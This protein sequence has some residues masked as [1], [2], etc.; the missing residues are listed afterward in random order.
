MDLRVACSFYGF[1][2]L[3][4]LDLCLQLRALRKEIIHSEQSSDK[5]KYIQYSDKETYVIKNLCQSCFRHIVKIYESKISID[6]RRLG[7]I[8]SR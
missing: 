6:I 8:N 5:N 4:H 2:C 7:T 1:R 3:K